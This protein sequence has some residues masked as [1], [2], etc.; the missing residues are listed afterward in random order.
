MGVEGGG[1]KH[2]HV[3]YRVKIFVWAILN[4]WAPPPPHAIISE[5]SI[6]NW[7]TN[8]Y[9]YKYEW[10]PITVEWSGTSSNCIMCTLYDPNNKTFINISNNNSY[11]C[12][13]IRPQRNISVQKQLKLF[14]N[15]AALL[16]M[17]NVSMF[18][19]RAWR[20]AFVQTSYSNSGQWTSE[21]LGITL[22]ILVTLMWEIL[23][24]FDE[25]LWWDFQHG[26]LYW[27]AFRPNYQ[28]K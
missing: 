27:Y 26:K 6:S 21:H 13:F 16:Q 1:V 23:Y 25:M 9:T 19:Y 15:R 8:M 18:I 20:N 17:Y 14:F 5:H 12:L 11:L 22:Y 28:A 7:F 10:N 4:F 3:S 2:F 24:E